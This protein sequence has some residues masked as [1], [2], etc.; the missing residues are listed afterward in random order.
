MPSFREKPRATDLALYP[1]MFPST[2]WWNYELLFRSLYCILDIILLE[3]VHSFPFFLAT[4]WKV[5]HQWCLSIVLH[6][7]T[8]FEISSLKV[9]SYYSSS[10][11]LYWI[12]VTCSSEQVS[13]FFACRQLCMLSFLQV[14]CICMVRNISYGIFIMK[15][16]L[17]K[18]IWSCNYFSEYNIH[19][20]LT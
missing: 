5:I 12:V 6:N 15:K 7:Y 11:I 20:Y 2:A 19:P 13:F 10:W 1:T 14:K 4:S 18:K 17:W 8:M 3:L 16:F 9:S